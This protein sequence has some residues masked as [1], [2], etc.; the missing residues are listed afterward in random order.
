[1]LRKVLDA[2]PMASEVLRVKLD[3][4]IRSDFSSQ[5]SVKDAGNIA[6]LALDPGVR[7]PLLECCIALYQPAEKAG[8]QALGMI[9]ITRAQNWH[10]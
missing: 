6:R 9:T 10:D 1:M 3:K 4:L 5:A 2:G 8:W 7:A